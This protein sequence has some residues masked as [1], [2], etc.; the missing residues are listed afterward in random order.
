MILKTKRTIRNE[1]VIFF[2]CIIAIANSILLVNAGSIIYTS[3]SPEHFQFTIIDANYG[4]LDDDGVKDDIWIKG[5]TYIETLSN[6]ANKYDLYVKIIAPLNTTYSGLFYVITRE[7]IH[8]YTILAYNTANSAG[9]YSIK[10][11]GILY[12][13]GDIY[14]SNSTFEFDPP[15]ASGSGSPTMSMI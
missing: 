5:R 15:T 2:F 13:T 14:Y 7:N 11:E 8:E 4:D 12:G 9:W 10:F 3:T 1:F 6:G